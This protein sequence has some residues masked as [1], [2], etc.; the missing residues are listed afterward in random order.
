MWHAWL[1]DQIGCGIH[2]F[3]IFKKSITT[4]TRS[5]FFNEDG[6]LIV[7]KYNMHV[8]DLIKP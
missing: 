3:I 7:N 4:S 1:H 5:H 2:V 6:I 8:D